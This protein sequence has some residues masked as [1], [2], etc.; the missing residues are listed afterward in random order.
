MTGQA[1]GDADINANSNP[2]QALMAEVIAALQIVQSGSEK[3]EFTEEASIVRALNEAGDLSTL[4]NA[5]TPEFKFSEL[6]TGKQMLP[7]NVN[8]PFDKI[9]QTAVNQLPADKT[10][11]SVAAQPADTATVKAVETILN[12]TV[13][14]ETLGNI[15]AEH[16]ITRAEIASTYREVRA[17]SLA[18]KITDIEN[19]D[20]QKSGTYQLAQLLSRPVAIEAREVPQMTSDNTSRSASVPAAIVEGKT[21]VE[22]NV[23]IDAQSNDDKTFE[24]NQADNTPELH[25]AP[26][27][28]NAEL[29]SEGPESQVSDNADAPITGIASGRD[30]KA[31]EAKLNAAKADA[32]NAA[33]AREAIDQV[34]VKVR[35]AAENGVRQVSVKLNPPELGRIDVQIDMNADG[36]TSLSIMA[37]N[38][39][40]LSMMQK[41]ARELER[42]LMDVGIKTDMGSLNFNLRGDGN[43]QFAGND[44]KPASFYGKAYG[45]SGGE[46]EEAVVTRVIKMSNDE[47]NIVV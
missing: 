38:R 21:A 40:T 4:N 35:A 45:Q 11:E 31:V 37:D 36:K 44:N 13:N 12:T 20:T 19:T 32:P 26:S 42:S 27:P 28:A 6:V 29:Q 8:A 41:G 10:P 30:H 9:Q 39:E 17:E 34:V 18:A 23:Q 25:I 15:L 16:G 3:T 24:A 22:I 7:A 43:Q 1:Q 14:G 47:L 2:L 33:L 5:K 46:P